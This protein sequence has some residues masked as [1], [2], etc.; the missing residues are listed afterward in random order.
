MINKLFSNVKYT[1]DSTPHGFAPSIRKGVKGQWSKGSRKEARLQLE[2]AAFEAEEDI[3]N[4]I[5]PPHVI[6][7]EDGAVCSR[8]CSRRC[9]GD[10]GEACREDWAFLQAE[11][12]EARAAETFEETF[13]REGREL[14]ERSRLDQEAYDTEMEEYLAR[15]S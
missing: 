13:A 7:G 5:L 9:F 11:K 6:V 1:L 10:M 8:C 4:G 2:L 14:R 3:F 15:I 12:M